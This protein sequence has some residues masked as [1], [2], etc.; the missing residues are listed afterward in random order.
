MSSAT[1]FRDERLS[2][3]FTHPLERR[4]FQNCG[5]TRKQGVSSQS[6]LYG[7]CLGAHF[8]SCIFILLSQILC[9]ETELSEILAKSAV[10]KEELSKIRKELVNFQDQSEVAGLKAELQEVL[11]CSSPIDSTSYQ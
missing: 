5:R 8:D 6:L 3:C 11:V 4:P 2:C 10:D 9:L 1:N 7:F